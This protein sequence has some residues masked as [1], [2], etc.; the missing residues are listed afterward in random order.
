MA[1]YRQPQQN[2]RWQQRPRETEFTQNWQEQTQPDPTLEA[3]L[4]SGMNSGI[5]FDKYEEIP[6][7]ATGKDCPAPITHVR[8]VQFVYFNSLLF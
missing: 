7:E 8:I 4:F 1:W 2:T 3:E 6:V 5:N